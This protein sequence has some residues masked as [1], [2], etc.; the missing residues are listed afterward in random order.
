MP[1][2]KENNI[3]FETALKELHTIVDNMEKG[4]LTL[5]QS[6]AQFERGISLTRVCQ[7]SLKDAEQKVQ[8]LMAQTEQLKPFVDPKAE[9][10]D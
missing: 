6:L 9:D 3:D 2:A 8:V 1:K 5:E 7:Q 4:G 10:E